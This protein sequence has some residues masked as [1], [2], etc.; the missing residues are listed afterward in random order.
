MHIKKIFVTGGNGFIGRHLI[1]HLLKKKYSVV[2]FDNSYRWDSK[3]L[4]DTI[5]NLN[6]SNFKSIEGD[7]SDKGLVD[8][9]I[10]TCDI[11]VHLAG[12]SQVITSISNPSL[13]FEYNVNGL[14]NIIDACV[15]NNKKIIFAS[16]REVYGN[17]E[18]FPVDINHRLKPENIYGESKVLGEKMIKSTSDNSNLDYTILRLSNVYGQGDK[19][20]VVPILIE[21]SINNEPIT[22]YGDYKILDLVHISD[23]IN[24]FMACIEKQESSKQVFNIGSGKKITL[25]ELVK[26]ILE[27]VGSKSNVINS[28]G[29]LGEVDY[30]L[31]DITETERIINWKPKKQILKLKNIVKSY[32]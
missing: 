13:T 1:K 9:L 32:F 5:K 18:Y 16:S 26:L 21:K 28:S 30:F 29:R 31:A 2:S 14:S 22:I 23:V 12:I 8:G 15:R 4:L 25:H 27:I 20:R 3:I 6:I 7:I 19:G 17:A 10:K 11:V 24:A